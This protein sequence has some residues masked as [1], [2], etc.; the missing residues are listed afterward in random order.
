MRVATRL[1][2][3]ASCLLV[4]A[5]PTYAQSP[6]DPSGHWEGFV[7][8]PDRAISIELDLAKKPSG[9]LAGTFA[10]PE[11]GVRALP[12]MTVT[13]EGRNVRFIVKGSEQPSTFAGIVA[14]DGKTMNGEVTLGEYVVPFQLTRMGDARVTAAPRSP[15]I[16]SALEGTWNGAI[17]SAM[18]VI[19]KMANQADGTSAGT[20]VSPYGSATEIPIAIAQTGT[21]VALDVDA[22]GGRFEGELDAATGQLV[23]TWRQATSSLPLT[24]TRAPK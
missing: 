3:F 23:G 6:V 4:S 1:V 21:R 16:D 9:E 7:Q 20:I 2:V 14:A 17:N 24:L 22:I 5:T 13:T 11:Q 8:V 12:L 19:V 15:R 18:R 10:Q